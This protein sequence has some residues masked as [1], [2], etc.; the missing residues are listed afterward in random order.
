MIHD[1]GFDGSRIVSI[2]T[3][4]DLEKFN[5]T[6]IRALIGKKGFSV[7]TVSIL[8]SWK[9]HYY[10]IEAVPEILKVVPEAHF[11]IVGDGLHRDTIARH[12]RQLSLEK[13]I[14]MA[15]HREDIPEILAS[16]DLIVHPSYANEGVPQSIL[17]AM[18]MERPVVATDT[19]AVSEAVLD[20]RTGFL[21]PPKNPK[22]IAEKVIELY[23]SPELRIQFG[24]EGRKLVEKE[25]SL[26]RMLDKMEALYQQVCSEGR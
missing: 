19:G 25:Y 9:G 18:A 13:K 26:D 6:K 2:P 22:A 17:Q 16:L 10:L 24:R 23:R 20:G 5:P 14:L 3:G 8:R 1:N 21:I 12:I 15:G 11:I 4:I 7:G